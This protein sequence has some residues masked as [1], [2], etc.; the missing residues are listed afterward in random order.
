MCIN[1]ENP[2]GAHDFMLTKVTLSRSLSRTVRDQDDH[3]ARAPALQV[4]I[5]QHRYTMRDAWS[6]FG[7]AF[8]RVK[9]FF[10]AHASQKRQRETESSK[11]K[12]YTLKY[13]ISSVYTSNTTGTKFSTPPVRDSRA[14][15][16]CRVCPLKLPPAPL[17]HRQCLF[18]GA[19]THFNVVWILL[20]VYTALY[21]TSICTMY[22]HMRHDLPQDMLCTHARAPG[23]EQ[24]CGGFKNARIEPHAF[25]CGNSGGE[26]S[27][28]V[29]NGGLGGALLLR[30]PQDCICR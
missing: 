4:N 20:C 16:V 7:A 15:C 18:L 12:V 3:H 8:V 17:E 23:I 6:I 30:G 2:F 24:I 5:P 13:A 1:A 21:W 25:V 26:Q 9:T 14:T 28:P 11:K 19:Q 22:K 29:A 27:G 10:G